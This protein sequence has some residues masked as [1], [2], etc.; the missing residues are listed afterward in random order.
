MSLFNLAQQ[1]IRTKPVKPERAAPRDDDSGGGTSEPPAAVAG[2]LKRLVDFIPTE[3]IML[4]WIAVPAAQGLSKW[5]KDTYERD[6]GWMLP[7]VYYGMLILTPLLLLLA[8]LS[9]LASKGEPR[10][11]LKTW[12]WWKAFASTIAFAI[13]ALAVPGNPYFSEPVLLMAVWAAATLVSMILGLI[14]PIV[15]KWFSAV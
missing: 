3:T 2:A 9:G 14:D 7:A 6:G 1:S 13:W 11:P 8:Y 12:P 15:V 5:Y 4:Y 10:P